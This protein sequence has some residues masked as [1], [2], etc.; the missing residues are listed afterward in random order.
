MNKYEIEEK[1]SPK[2][3]E[4][5]IAELKQQRDALLAACE[6]A[7]DWLRG[8]LAAVNRPASLDKKLMD[9]IAAAKE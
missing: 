5:E 7:E 9:A 8:H 6:D 4:R 3:Y 2:C 1:R